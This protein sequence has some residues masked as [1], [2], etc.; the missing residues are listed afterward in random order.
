MWIIEGYAD[1][2][3]KPTVLYPKYDKSKTLLV[4]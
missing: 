3:E 1:F 2:E 4:S